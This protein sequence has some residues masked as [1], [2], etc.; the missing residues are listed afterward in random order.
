MT[1]S[2]LKVSGHMYKENTLS[3]HSRPENDGDFDKYSRKSPIKELDCDSESEDFL[4]FASSPGSS[5][6]KKLLANRLIR[7]DHEIVR[8]RLT[9]NREINSESD[10]EPYKLQDI[11][12][13]VRVEPS[14]L[15][16]QLKSEE[17]CIKVK[18]PDNVQRLSAV[19]GRY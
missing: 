13:R 4:S 2:D 10:S 17:S 19:A 3:H 6:Q 16:N 9:L 8:R 11:S 5:E 18:A 15:M 1:E 12:N 7:N 14:V